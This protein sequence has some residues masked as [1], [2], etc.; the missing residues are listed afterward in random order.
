MV[1]QLV[2]SVRLMTY[3]HLCFVLFVLLHVSGSSES[4]WSREEAPVAA[5][6]VGI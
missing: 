3:G 2:A 1:Q 6:I 4:S 5:D